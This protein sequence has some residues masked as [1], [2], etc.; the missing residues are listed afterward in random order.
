VVA[1]PSDLQVYIGEKGVLW[2]HVRALGRTAH[3]SMPSLGVNAVSYVARLIPRL[4]AY[5]FPWKENDLL[6]QPTLSVNVIEGG[7]KMNVVP[8]FCRIEV[9]MRTVPGQV[10]AEMVSTLRSI[11]E[12]EARAYHPDLRVEVEVDNDKPPIETDRSEPLVDA[13]VQSVAA[14]RGSTPEVGGVS[15][16]TDAACLGPGFGIPMVICGPGAPSMAHQPDE[17]VEVEQLVQA[18]QIYEDVA[19]RLLG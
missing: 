8:D 9:D 5:P 16:G 14:V 6:G 2:M 17:Y 4:E 3:G 1:E 11:A 12:G 19:R 10:H 7:N 13:V 18:A 15:Y